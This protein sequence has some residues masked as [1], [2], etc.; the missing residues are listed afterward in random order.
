MRKQCSTW[1]IMT[2][3]VQGLIHDH[4]FGIIVL[5]FSLQH[6]VQRN[7]NCAITSLVFWNVNTPQWLII[8]LVVIVM[9]G[10]VMRHHLWAK[11]IINRRPLDTSLITA[12]W[13]AKHCYYSLLITSGHACS[14]SFWQTTNIVLILC[15]NW[16]D[17]CAHAHN[18]REAEC[19]AKGSLTLHV[20]H[21]YRRGWSLQSVLCVYVV[22][23][24]ACLL[25]VYGYGQNWDLPPELVGQCN[26]VRAWP[27]QGHNKDILKMAERNKSGI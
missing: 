7:Q 1:D 27:N 13:T 23:I 18:S 8:N 14:D 22:C 10:R 16:G 2:C 19:C 26:V 24:F 9:L 3:A 15:I 6:R 17:R 20:R 25:K 4:G 12:A 5:Y 21:V 11:C